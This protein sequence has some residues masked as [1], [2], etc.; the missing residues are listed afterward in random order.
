[1]IPVEASFIR[2]GSPKKKRST[3][4]TREQDEPTTERQAAGP[5]IKVGADG[6]GITVD[7]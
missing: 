4:P 7:D 6:L 2:T 1:M 5:R 3:I